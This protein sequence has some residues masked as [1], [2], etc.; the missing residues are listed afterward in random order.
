MEY[1]VEAVYE[2]GV[3]KLLEPLDLPEHQRV[4]VTVQP[5]LTESPSAELEAW[6]QVYSG[7]SDDEIK[8][9]EAIALDRSQFM[10]QEK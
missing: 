2:S 9:I 3:L 10:N 8:E 6:H 1:A 7:F 5:S 4:I